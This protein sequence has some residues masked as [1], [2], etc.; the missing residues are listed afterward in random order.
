MK[1]KDAL[2]R[3]QKRSTFISG[4]DMLITISV[5]DRDAQRAADLANGYIDALRGPNGLLA[6]TEAAQR[7]LFFQEQLECEKN[8]L[9][10]A[11]VELKKK[12]EQTGLVAPNLTSA[13]AK[14]RLIGRPKSRLKRLL[15]FERRLRVVRWNLRPSDSPL[16]LCL[17]T[18]GQVTVRP[19]S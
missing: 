8:D 13:V 18:I 16:S 2:K 4:K 5:E 3:L 17:M 9:P 12:E 19:R 6:L 1:L 11:G 7:R 14:V 15:K 10:D